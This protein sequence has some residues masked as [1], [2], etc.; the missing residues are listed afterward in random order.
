MKTETEGKHCKKKAKG[1]VSK[2]KELA[3][4]LHQQKKLEDERHY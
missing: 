3:R 2:Y 1:I 4:E